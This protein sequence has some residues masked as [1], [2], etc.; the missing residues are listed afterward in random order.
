M[1]F[2]QLKY[3]KTEK[4]IEFEGETF[5]RFSEIS[6]LMSFGRGLL[7]QEYLSLVDTLRLTP[8][9]FGK[10]VERMREAIN[11]DNDKVITGLSNANLLLSQLEEC[12]TLFVDAEIA[13]NVAYYSLFKPEDDPRTEPGGSEKER[14]LDLFKKKAL[15]LYVLSPISDII[16]TERLSRQFSPMPLTAAIQYSQAKGDAMKRFWNGEKVGAT[17][18]GISSTG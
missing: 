9:T 2:E 4:A 10:W 7:L 13:A 15:Q 14:R 1:T 16:Q 11:P 3:N 17:G 6:E 5:Y 12:T 18:K 8:E